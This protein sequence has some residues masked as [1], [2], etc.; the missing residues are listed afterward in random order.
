MCWRVLTSVD[1][2]VC[3]LYWHIL[4]CMYCNMQMCSDT[5]GDI[6]NLPEGWSHLYSSCVSAKHRSQQ[7]K[8]WISGS[9]AKFFAATACE[10]SKKSPPKFGDYRPSC[11]SITTPHLTLSYS[12][13]IFWRNKKLAVFPQPPYSLALTPCD[14][15]H[16]Q[17]WNWSWKDAGLLPL[18]RSSQ[19]RRGR[20]W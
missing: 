19:N 1:M 13:S 18:R 20:V 7:A 16:F 2:S 3:W 15:S 9:T 4:T 17:K 5:R 14:F 12:P 8:L 10:R 6:Q 11:F